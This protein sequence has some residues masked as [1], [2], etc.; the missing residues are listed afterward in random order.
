VIFANGGEL[1][2]LSWLAKS[3][4]ESLIAVPYTNDVYVTPDTTVDQF[5]ASSTLAAKTLVFTAEPASE[6][7]SAKL[8]SDK[9]T[10]TVATAESVR[11]YYLKTGTSNQLIGSGPILRNVVAG[12]K[13][14]LTLQ[15]YLG[16]SY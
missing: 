2:L 11:G 4:N 3:C 13:L 9:L 15:F 14:N 12:D 6:N 8:S 10:W 1:V 16:G 7:G 5:T